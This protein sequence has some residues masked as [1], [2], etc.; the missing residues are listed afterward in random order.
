M[1]GQDRAGPPLTRTSFMATT[2]SG[3]ESHIEKTPKRAQKAD[4]VDTLPSQGSAC[5]VKR[6]GGARRPAM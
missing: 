5:P 1:R 2:H 4:W 6:S 3:A